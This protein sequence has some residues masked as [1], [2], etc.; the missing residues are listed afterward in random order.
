M[1]SWQLGSEPQFIYFRIVPVFLENE[2]Y[3]IDNNNPVRINYKI[4]V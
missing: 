2:T 4:F 1:L 3:L